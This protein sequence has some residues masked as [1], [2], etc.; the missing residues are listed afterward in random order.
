MVP[1]PNNLTYVFRPL[2]L[3][4]NKTCKAYLRKQTQDWLSRQVQVQLQNGV[5]PENVNVDM[6]ISTL[7]RLHAKW[8]TSLH[9]KM[10]SR[11]D[12]IIK[13]WKKSGITDIL[14]F[15]AGSHGD[16]ID[17]ILKGIK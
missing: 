15:G 1:V 16:T 7:K 2:D 3:T 9:D 12:I 11:S 5:Q 6:K 14:E 10:Q 13:G 17:K 4:V 8:I